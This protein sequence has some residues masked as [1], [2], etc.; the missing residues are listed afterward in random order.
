[1]TTRQPRDIGSDDCVF[2]RVIG[3]DHIQR[4]YWMM[5]YA[6]Y[7]L[8][9]LDSA[10]L[11]LAPTLDEIRLRNTHATALLHALGAC[12]AVPPAALIATIESG[13]ATATGA[14]F[15][16]IVS[17][18]TPA[19]RY[20]VRVRRLPS[21]RGVLVEATLA[22]SHEHQRELAEAL[23]ARRGLSRRDSRIVARVCAGLSNVEIAHEMGLTCGTVR[24]YLSSIFAVFGV[25]S[26]TQL[27]GAIESLRSREA[28]EQKA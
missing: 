1:V 10:I 3:F 12:A 8:D 21:S 13:L 2:Q 14:G 23:F 25:H 16:Q 27:I 26:R 20:A 7:L 17:L 5:D 18:P 24:Q 19:G 11:L 4:E 22:I 28:V 9:Q 15:S 6:R